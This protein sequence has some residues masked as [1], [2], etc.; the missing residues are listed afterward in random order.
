MTR[1]ATI[2]GLFVAW[3]SVL[4]VSAAE[5]GTLK[6]TSFPSGAQ[7][8]VDGADTGKVTA[9]NIALSEGEHI[10][11]VRIPNSGWNADT[12]TVTIVAGNNDLSVTLLPILSSGP[13]D[14]AGNHG[15]RSPGWP[16]AR[17]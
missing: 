5:S 13:L 16:A 17:R 7:V 9:M 6:V 15:R 3:M 1:V 11:T 2:A 8:L 4:F 14:S 12:R 10:V